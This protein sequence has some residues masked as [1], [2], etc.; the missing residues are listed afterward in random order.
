M[1]RLRALPKARDR[2]SFLYFEHCRIEQEGRAIAIFKEKSKFFVPCAAISTLLLGPGTTITHAAIK[3]LADNVCEVQWVGEDVMRFYAQGRSGANNTKRLIHQATLWA[4]SIQRLAVVRRMYLFRFNEPLDDNLT[5][6]QIRGHE[7]VRVRTLY[8]RW[9]KQTGVEWHGRNYKVGNW[10][11]AN[12]INRALSIANT[13]L[14]AVCQAAIHSVGY[15]PA[16]GFIHT[17]NPLSF[18]YDIADL[19]K[20]ETTIPAAFE[21]VADSYFDL[22]RWVRHRCHR[23]FADVRLMHR[24][25]ADID[26]VLG[27][28]TEEEAEPICFLW[29]DILETVE[30]G[31][32]WSDE[33][34][35]P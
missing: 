35:S 1:S 18:V 6:Q 11:A 16:L 19:Y 3:T 32:N 12:P 21:A 17:G 25:V 24:I 15:S 9:S 34:D 14:Y 8:Q 2:I 26:K 33:E 5:L 13:C 10:D 30:G 29:D 31:K 23:H 4:D 20:A 7:G 22:D 27:F 28:N